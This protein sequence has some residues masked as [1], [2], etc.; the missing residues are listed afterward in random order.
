MSDV[1]MG[2]GLGVDLP[3]AVSGEGCWLV[4]AD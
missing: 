4:D 2:R 1:L 3:V